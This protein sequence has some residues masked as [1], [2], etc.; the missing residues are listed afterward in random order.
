M[1]YTLI[2]FKPNQKFHL[3]DKETGKPSCIKARNKDMTVFHK[4]RVTTEINTRGTCQQCIGFFEMAEE[5]REIKQAESKFVKESKEKTILEELIHYLNVTEPEL[6][7]MD[8]SGGKEVLS[9]EKELIASLEKVLPRPVVNVLIQYVMLKTDKKLTKSYTEK[10]AAHWSRKGIE[11][12]EQAI[13]IAK[14]EHQGY[15]QWKDSKYKPKPQPN[16][17]YFQIISDLQKQIGIL[18]Y[19]IEQLEKRSAKGES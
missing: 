4:A 17:D 18:E 13:E 15:T 11:T 14:K 5:K 9:S 7:L 2:Q 1:E 12:A 10:I 6:L 19:R 8:I 3:L 16:P